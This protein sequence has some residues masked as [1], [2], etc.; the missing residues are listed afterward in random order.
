MLPSCC[1]AKPR[2]HLDNESASLNLAMSCLPPR[3]NRLDVAETVVRQ[4]LAMRPQ[5]GLATRMLAEIE[6]LK[7]Q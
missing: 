6:R 4:V 3:G 2:G 5:H 1:A 7:Q